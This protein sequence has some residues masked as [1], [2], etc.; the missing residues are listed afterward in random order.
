MAQPNRRD[1]LRQTAAA[2][3]TAAAATTPWT[4]KVEAKPATPVRGGDLAKAFDGIHLTDQYGQAFDPEKILGK[5]DCLV[6]FGYGGC[7]LCEEISNS[8]AAIQKELL[9]NQLDVPIVVV[10]AQPDA[11]RYQPDAPNPMKSYIAKYH[12]KGV[13]QFATS[14]LSENEGDRQSEGEQIYD[15]AASSAATSQSRRILHV[16]CPPSI[17][18][19]QTIEKRLGLIYN[20][21]DPKSHTAFITH[22]HHGEK[23]Q[24]YR[25]LESFRSSDAF[26]G[27]LAKEVTAGIQSLNRQR[28]NGRD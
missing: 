13:K 3:A 18:D 28:H 2:V 23:M 21:N 14:P 10:S 7:P 6:L 1:F 12:E 16:V 19:T 11:D 26:A 27:K 17:Q 22:Y 9:A 20:P 24:K 25:A 5:K 8:V 15:N 4:A